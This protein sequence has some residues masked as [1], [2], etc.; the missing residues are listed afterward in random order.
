VTVDHTQLRET[1]LAYTAL[2]R[3][4][5]ARGLAVSQLI[6]HQQLQAR[7]CEMTGKPCTARKVVAPGQS[8]KVK[9]LGSWSGDR[10]TAVPTDPTTA[11]RSHGVATS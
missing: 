7:L 11:V 2:A 4:R 5:R 9:P 10:V 8:A 6:T 3:R 1:L